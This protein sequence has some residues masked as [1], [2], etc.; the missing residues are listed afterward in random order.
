MSCLPTIEQLAHRR[1]GLLGFGRAGQAAARAL[2]AG[3]SSA[4]VTVL[5]ESGA[6][7]TDLPVLHGTFGDELRGFDALIRSPGVPVDHPALVAARAAGVAIINPA[8]LWLA[9][10]AADMTVV[11]VTGSKGKSTTASL[12]AHL[13]SACGHKTLLAGNIGVPLLDHLNTDAGIAVIELSSYQLADLEGRLDMGI[14]TSLFPEH[15]DW[16][17][18][19]RAYI[20]AKLRMVK[21]LEG[22]P[23]LVNAGDGRLAAATEGLFGRISANR[24]PLA[25]R[26]GANVLVK[27]DVRV[28]G[29]ELQLIGRHNLDNA[30][31]ALQAALQLGCD[32]RRLAAALREFRP[33]P[34]RLEPVAVING[35]RYINDSISTNP[36]S[37]RAALEALS[38]APVIL[39]AG[40][41]A[42]TTCWQPVLE[43]TENNELAGLIALPDNG[44]GLADAYRRQRARQGDP[45]AHRIHQAD[46]L[47]DAVELAAGMAPEG[48]VVLL[49][50]GAPSFGRYRDFEQRGEHFRRAVRALANP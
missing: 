22:R 18:S 2:Q 20:D 30:A 45:R 25:R 5:V 11:G 4:D 41:H 21:L 39:I 26:A 50:P 6:A 27:D 14:M 17:G 49:S 9:E 38:P 8:S 7:D 44:C 34:H 32:V 15:L 40:G 29:R 3:N 13:L 47:D 43:W 46:Q 10:R 28:D 42:R 12:L 36:W 48:G 24:A 16:H 35:V 37:A 19:E 23:L 31:L 33:L 1:I